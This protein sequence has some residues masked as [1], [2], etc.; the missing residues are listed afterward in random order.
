MGETKFRFRLK[1]KKGYVRFSCFYYWPRN[2]NLGP[3][4]TL[5]SCFSKFGN[6]TTNKFNSGFISRTNNFSD[7]F[8][9]LTIKKFSFWIIAINATQA[10]LELWFLNVKI[11]VIETINWIRFGVM[12]ERSLYIKGWI[13]IAI[14][15]RSKIV[16]KRR[17]WNSPTRL[18]KINLIGWIGMFTK[19]A[20]IN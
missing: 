17:G 8:R 20:S 13:I 10:S 15:R 18:G 11:W 16:F 12:E 4:L 1:K 19:G 2:L 5:E 7:C 3:F 6:Q 14:N 9:K